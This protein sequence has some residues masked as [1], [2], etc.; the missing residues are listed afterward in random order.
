MSED[1]DLFKRFQAL[2]SVPVPFGRPLHTLNGR[3]NAA[4]DEDEELDA[5]A[6]GAVSASRV[7]PITA[8]NDHDE[9]LHKRVKALKGEEGDGDGDGDGDGVGDLD[10]GD[11][12]NCDPLWMSMN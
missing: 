5:I 4:Q 12:V 11:E 3:A 7:P 9:D 6:Q 10:L 1:D 2:R 8:R